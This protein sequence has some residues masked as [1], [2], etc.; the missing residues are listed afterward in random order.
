M[1]NRYD[2]NNQIDAKAVLA[3]QIERTIVTLFKQY[4]DILHEL[5]L[6]HDEALSKLYDNLPEQYKQYVELADYL[7]DNKRDVLRKKVLTMGN[8]AKRHLGELLNQ[9]DIELK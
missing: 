2:K 9:F 3:F 5:G 8:D 6:E 1:D 7:S 4:L